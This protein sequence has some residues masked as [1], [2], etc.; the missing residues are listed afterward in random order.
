MR[1]PSPPAT[2]SHFPT[3]MR[4]RCWRFPGSHEQV[5]Q[6]PIQLR[7]GTPLVNDG[8]AQAASARSSHLEGDMF[9]KKRP[10]GLAGA[11]RRASMQ[12]AAASWSATLEMPHATAPPVE[13][14]LAQS[15]TSQDASDVSFL[16]LG[17]SPPPL[18]IA[19]LQIDT[20][21]DKKKD[22]NAIS[23][24][25]LGGVAIARS[26][27]NRALSL[28]HCALASWAS[29]FSLQVF[30]LANCLGESFRR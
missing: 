18:L 21:R 6:E 19:T 24:P 15:R 13:M 26:T 20:C 11:R 28:A 12:H 29:S 30:L 17:L 27:K 3:S 9:K 8:D 25:V 2:P 14:H 16:Y 4:R 7:D 5:E 23:E 1:S 10:H 22:N